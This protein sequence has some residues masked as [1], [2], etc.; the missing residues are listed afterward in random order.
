[1]F[2]YVKPYIPS[3]TVAEYE[4]YRGAYCGLCRTMGSLTGQLSRFTLNYDFAFLAIF[5]MALERIP[6]EFE[7]KGCIAHPLT[8]RTHMKRN[9]AL[10]YCAAASAVLT[11]GK[12]RDNVA[13]ESG[14]AKFGATLLTP[15]GSSLARRVRRRIGELEEKVRGDLSA[16][17]EIEAAR[18]ASLDAPADAFAALLSSVSAYGLEGDSAKIAAEVGRALGKI[19]YV[20]DAADDISDDLK[21]EKYNPIALLY[22]EPTDGEKKDSKGRP[23]LK[24]EIAESL[25]TAVGIEANRAA[26][27]FELA[28][29]E[30][31]GTYKGIIMNTLTLGVRAEAERIF[32]GRGDKEDPVRFRI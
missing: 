4:A 9:P 32:F 21:G 26:A 22:D 16:L 13:D 3:L 18:T 20:F 12:I 2:G 10:E 14:F 25:Y 19:V 31:V 6:A 11:A 15:L 1:M 7:R 28:P 23:L 5:R 27:A 8:R 30:G 24:R 17:A 29:E